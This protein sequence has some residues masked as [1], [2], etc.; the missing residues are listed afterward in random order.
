MNEELKRSGPRMW[1]GC[2]A[3]VVW[4]LLTGTASLLGV[5][6]IF[7]PSPSFAVAVWADFWTYV[8]IILLLFACAVFFPLESLLRRLLI[9]RNVRRAVIGLAVLGTLVAVFYTVENWRGGR[10]WEQCRRELE[11]RGEKLDWEA[12]IP[13]PLP[14]DQNF[15]KAPG[16]TAW[17]G[18]RA[19]DA[20]RYVRKFTGPP[21]ICWPSSLD[22]IRKLPESMPV[23]VTNSR[24]VRTSL[25]FPAS[26]EEL[27]AA[28]A[29]YEPEYRM[30]V[31]ACLRPKSHREDNVGLPPSFAS[32]GLVAS[33]LS[34]H[35]RLNLSDGQPE[36]A[37]QDLRMMRRVGEVMDDSH[38]VVGT[39]HMISASVLGLY[40]R[41]ARDGLEAGLWKEPQLAIIQQEMR[42]VNSLAS[43]AVS[44]RAER[45]S[46]IRFLERPSTEVA[47]IL[48]MRTAHGLQF[49]PP[50]LINWRAALARLGMFCPRGWI[51]QN[52]ASLSR[53]YQ[54]LLDSFDAGG[55]RIQ[56]GRLDALDDRRKAMS[57]RV[58][59]YYFLAAVTTPNFI[60]ALRALAWNQTQLD[61]LQ[62]ACAMERYRLTH[63]N[64]PEKLDALIPAYLDQT[65]KDLFADQPLQ[66]RRDAN[67]AYLLW[68]VGWNEKDD[69]GVATLDESG[70]PLYAAREGDWV[71]SF[72]ALPP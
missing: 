18:S 32:A 9:W 15:F 29:E 23:S 21:G 40:A 71:W 44:L 5:F 70:K 6:A 19:W 50:T 66:Y 10:A 11:A 43:F 36:V 61:Q 20:D 64:Y 72:R 45:A 38:T 39:M 30:L 25:P 33:S 16:M 49:N 31:V 27:R 34:T 58:T 24:L 28:F 1:K 4:A 3:I 37:V 69:G 13:Q 56:A 51:Q 48:G 41:T 62:V 47:K 46:A 12:F 53:S 17:F 59:P 68:S 54:D 65:P 63:G 26:R 7:P 2:A 35:A 42:T 55:R 14:D 22:E 60:Q 67:G 57:G 8:P 52:Q